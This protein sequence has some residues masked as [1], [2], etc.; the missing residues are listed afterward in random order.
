MFFLGVFVFQRVKNDPAGRSGPSGRDRFAEALRS[1]SSLEALEAAEC[2]CGRFG[3]PF[4][5]GAEG[6]RVVELSG[7]LDGDTPKAPNSPLDRFS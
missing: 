6:F 7:N 5:G 2:G 4:L 1:T 3:G